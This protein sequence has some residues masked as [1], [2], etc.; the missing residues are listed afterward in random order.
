[1]DLKLISLSIKVFEFSLSFQAIFAIFP[2]Q[3]DLSFSF[4]RQ[5]TELLA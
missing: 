2:S 3:H 5:I 1:M 4:T